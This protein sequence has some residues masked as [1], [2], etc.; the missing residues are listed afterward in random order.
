VK[1]MNTKLILAL[2]AVATVATAIL[3]VAAAQF[4]TNPEP[5]ANNVNDQVEPPCVT[6]DISQ[7]PEWCLNQT[8]SEPYCFQNSTQA[9]GYEYGYGFG[10][11]CYG[12]GYAYGYGYGC[13]EGYES[14]HQQQYAG[15]GGY[16]F[17]GCR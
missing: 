3:G 11:G 5:Y 15:R 10:G 13:A 7:V 16:G 12:N 8:T 6:G 1:N 14:Q 2:A 9:H 17:G 4:A